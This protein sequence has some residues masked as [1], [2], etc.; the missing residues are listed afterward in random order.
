MRITRIQPVVFVLLASL[1]VACGKVGDAPEAKTGEAVTI[2]EGA[3]GE[4]RI[5]T[6]R[7]K[8]GWKAAKVTAAH[9]GGFRQFDGTVSVD[10]DDVTG[11]RLNIQTSSIW[12]DNE[13]L[14]G[15]LKS[16][17]FF[18][19]EEHPTATFEADRFEPIDS[20]GLTHMVTGNLQLLG[21]T[22]AVTFPA[23]I[24]VAGNEVKATGDFIINRKDWGIVY[25]GAPDDLIRDDV[26]LLLDITAVKGEPVAAR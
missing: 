24:T 4:F 3:G 17:D 19:V 14:T 20:A 15:H 18:K 26:R 11:V 22:K 25:A 16:P 13:K 7:S 21:A 5:D 1:V 9:D 8:I 23:T 2:Q 12:S 6:T 10:G